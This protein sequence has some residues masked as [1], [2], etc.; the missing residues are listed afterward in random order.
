MTVTLDRTNGVTQKAHVQYQTVPNGGWSTPSKP[1]DIDAISGDIVLDSLKGNTEYE[2]QAWLETDANT[3]VKSEPFTTKPVP[4]GVP[5]NTTV[6]PGNTTIELAWDPPSDDGGS[7][8]DHYVIEWVEYLGHNWETSTLSSATTTDEEYEITGLTNG[9]RYAIRLR[10]DNF[11]PLPTGKSYFWVFIDAIPRTIPAAPT[12][13]VTPDNAKLH[14]EWNEPGNGGDAINGYVVEYSDD[15]KATWELH[16][17]P[18]SNTFQ[19]TI[20]NL[21]NGT[22]YFVQVRAKNDAVPDTPGV[23]NWGEDD[24]T[25]RTIPVEPEITVT[26]GDTVLVVS[27]NEPDNGGSDITSHVVQYKKNT[28]DAWETSTATVTKSTDSQTNLNS[29]ETTIISLENGTLYDVRVRAVN[30]VMLDNDGDY[31]WGEGSGK[32]RTIP[33]EPE[34]GVTP[35]NALLEVTWNKPASGGDDITSFVVQYMKDTDTGWSDHSTPG[36]DAT[37]TT[38]SSLENG[39]L[40][41]VRVRAVNSVVLEVEDNYN[42]GENSG[43]PRT[44]PNKPTSVDVTHGDKM[45]T[46]TWEAPEGTLPNGGDTITEYEIQ[47]K[48]KNTF[49][50]SSPSEGIVSASSTLE[51]EITDHLDQPL[52]NGVRYEVRVRA[53]NV[54]DPDPGKDYNWEYGEETPSTTP[55]APQKIRISNQGNK[56]LTVE[57]DA[58]VITGGDDISGYVVQWRAKGIA[59]WEATSTTEDDTIAADKFSHTFSQHLTVALANGLPYEARVIAKNRN[60]R[61]TPS[62]HVEGIPRTT[63]DAP[64]DLDVTEGNME[65][66]LTWTAPSETGGTAIDYYV[67]E[68]M[69]EGDSGFTSEQTDNASTNWTLDGLENGKLY[70]IRVKSHTEGGTSKTSGTATG[71]PRTIPGK[72]DITAVTAGN[73]TL[74]VAWTPPTDDGGADPTK[75]ILEWEEWIEATTT[76]QAAGSQEDTNGSPSEIAGLTNGTKYRVEVKAHNA[77]GAG[78]ASDPVE[79]TPKT[80]PDAPTVVLTPGNGELNVKW[81]EPGDGGDAITGFKVQYKKDTDTGWTEL[82]EFGATV[83]E[84]TISSLDNGDS[85]MVWVR[86]VNTA[87]PDAGKVYNWGKA[88]DIPRTFPAAPSVNLVHGDSQLKVTW[89]KPDERGATVTE[90]VVQYKKAADTTWREHSR[91]G[92]GDTTTDI[93]GL[94]NG[95]LYDVRVRAVNSVTLDDEELYAW[96]K[97]SDTPRTIPGFVT[98]LGIISGDE[99]LT[100]SWVAPTVENNGGAAVKG[101]VLQWKSGNEEYDPSSDRHTTTT[102]VSKVLEPLSNGILYSIRVRADN[103]ETADTYNWV[104]TTGTPMSVPGAPTGL[105]VEEGDRQIKVTWVAPEE[106]GGEGV[107]IERYVIQWKLET[108]SNWPS[109]NEHTTTDE[110]VLTDTITGLVNGEMYDIRVRADNNVEGQTFQ[111]GNTTGTPRTIPSEPRSLNVTPGDGQLSLTWDAPADTGGL[112]I[113]RYVVQWKS[114]TDP[115]NNSD[116]EGKPSNRSYV[117]RGLTNDVL[118]TFRVRADNTVTVPDEDNYNWETG[119]GTPV[120][121]AIP[122]PPPQRPQQPNNPPIQR[123]PTPSVSDVS[124]D[125]ITQTSARARVSIADAGSSQKSVHLRYR[126]DGTT[127]W[128]SAPAKK[129][130]GASATISLTG[131][132]AGT[133]Y[134][135][136]AWLTTNSPPS[137]TQIY[138]FTTLDELV[139]DPSISSLE[140]ENIGQT[141]A[142]AMVK[143]ANAGTDMKE[144]YLKH[145]MDGVDSWTTLPSPSVTY[146][147]STSISLTGLQVGTTYELA[148]ALTNDFNGMLTCSFTTLASDP[149]VSGIGISDI[150]NTS[151]MATVNI[152]SPG[153]AQ[154]SVHLRYREFGEAGWGTAQTKSTTGASAQFSLTSLSPRTTYEVQASLASDFSASRSV[155][156]TTSTPDPSVSGINMG[157]ITDTSASATVGIAHPGTAQKTVHLRYRVFGKSEWSTAQTGTTSGSSAQFD[158]TGLEPQTKYEVEAALSSDFIGSK[159]ATF[160]TFV[161]EPN[162]SSVSIGSIKQ[163]SAVATNSIADAGSSQKAVHLRYREEDTEEWSDPALTATTYGASVSIDLAGLTADTEYEVQASLDASFAAY[164]SA[165]F[166]TLRYPSLSDIDVT[167]ITKTTATAEISISDPDGSSQTVHLRY[168][169]TTPQDSWSSIQTTTSTSADA[170]IKLAGLVTDTEYE[171]QASLTSDFAISVTDTFTTLPPDPVVSKVSVNSIRQTTATALVD[172]ANANSD[173][174]TVRLRYRTTTPRGNWSSTLTTTS[175]TDSAT[176]DLSGLTP[177]TEYDVQASL[178]GT[179]PAARTKYDTFTTLRYP[180]IASLEAENIGRNGATV[181]ATIADSQGESQ[182]VYVR[183]RQSRYIAWRTTQQT[184]SVDDVASLRLRGLSSGMEYIAEASLDNTFPSDGTKSVTFT[185]KERK[186]DD[187]AV[188]V[189]EARSVSVPLPGFSPQMLRFVAIEGGDSPAPQTFSVWNRAQGTM[190]FILSN[191]QEW[192]SQEPTSGTS[193]GPA[194]PV[195]ITA[196]VDSSGLASGQYVDIISIDVS[197]SGRSPDQ[198]VVVLDVLPPDYVRQFVSREEGGTVILPDGTVKIVVQPLSP[199]K[200]VDIELMKLNLQAPGAPPGERERVVFAIES[201]TYEPGGDTPEDVAYLPYV[202]LWVMLPS[203]EEAACADGRVR[204]YSVQGDWSLLEHSCETDESGSVWAVADVKRLGAFALVIDDSPATPTPTPAAAT[205]A[206]PTGSVIGSA[207]SATVRTSLPAMPPT[208]VPTAVPTA[209][210]AP[211]A[212]ATAA[213]EPEATPMPT[214]TAVPAAVEPPAPAMQASADQGGSGGMS[215]VI[216]AAIG[217]PMLLGALLLGYLIYRER[218]RRNGNQREDEVSMG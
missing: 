133:T 63:P 108:A 173:R 51:L 29:Y 60:G 132:T 39:E 195:T 9:T 49:G 46:V 68:Y 18:G 71:K 28:D 174:Q 217:L 55:D 105:D 205:M 42:W 50:W 188:V 83:L 198:V 149:S 45:L 81:T 136:Q 171:V 23:F 216:L 176:I 76:W 97:K 168:R 30:V 209:V 182:T 47:W 64:D 164:A 166:A 2:V 144:V 48:E 190:D 41:T 77:A 145:S 211:I 141:F 16:G 14:V 100:V 58:P 143:I 1:G 94:D 11:E 89:D 131:L 69:K 98:G 194:D 95:V 40:Y 201:N 130:N 124:F 102:D 163:T 181:S 179:F 155:M 135:V 203:G 153:T 106:T 107:E 66:V 180:S 137:G 35:G 154:K 85:Y 4:P 20:P 206:T 56:E 32:P 156:F 169:T 161:P 151:A 27:W 157:N 148:V 24:G 15:D 5:T 59:N 118:H 187:D 146:T 210:P 116:R 62:V 43:K 84:T 185:T 74:T 22:K 178:D 8:I 80:I 208:P 186:D 67:V 204:L 125:N 184:D 170:S 200:D 34:V 128:T 70:T 162:V 114:G 13:T 152:A 172:I 88:S 207:S 192:L 138:E 87:E 175:S 61:G 26:P 191:Q 113:N 122:P 218:R 112:N 215:G 91:P 54:A 73:G 139:S 202:T 78:P 3:K 17:E 7:A 93:T 52:T 6:T 196:S 53:V 142:T 199:P 21:K 12:V 109:Q 36:K 104:E 134:E 119:T 72:P 183:H 99:E 111:W 197:A 167:D 193:N 127:R 140:C 159:T 25:P 57:W 101:Y 126:E 96:G 120:A 86:A 123:S 177:G 150:T 33:E 115:Y 44:I 158:L 90:F 213:P 110:T 160:A 10:A 129:T 214:A 31:E 147:D 165:S 82:T 65:L 212:Q 103:G 189:Q 37:S 38:I 121:A 92:A 79:R 75:Y 19:T 117:I